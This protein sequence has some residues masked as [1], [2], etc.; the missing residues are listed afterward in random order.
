MHK[1]DIAWRRPYATSA[2]KS[3][4]T[5]TKGASLTSVLL[6]N[7]LKQLS[8]WLYRMKVKTQYFQKL[9]P[10]ALSAIK[11]VD[12]YF[13][14]GITGL[15]ATQSVPPKLH[16]HCVLTH[17]PQTL[18]STQRIRASTR[19]KVCV[20]CVFD[21][22]AFLEFS[23]RLSHCYCWLKWCPR[24]ELNHRHEDFQCRRC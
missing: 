13:A 10:L 12:C 19:Q 17:K 15:C 8:V 4:L 22:R 21:I 23:T 5:L 24:A 16:Q 11:F 6:Q 7:R 20:R 9:S 1:G 14:H 18:C 2:L 3:L